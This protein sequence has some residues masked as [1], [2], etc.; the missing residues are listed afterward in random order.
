ML[1]VICQTWKQYLCN[2][3]ILTKKLYTSNFQFLQNNFYLFCKCTVV[4]D[5]HFSAV[6]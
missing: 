2:A 5:Q 4:S 6:F 3:Y 1:H